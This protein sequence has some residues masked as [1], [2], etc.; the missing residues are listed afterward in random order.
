[1]SERMLVQFAEHLDQL[2]QTENYRSF[3]KLYHQGASIHLDG[4]KL[5]NLAS[6]D[7]LGV[8]SDE[9]LQAQF[10]A[11]YQDYL[12]FGSSSSRL[13]T[14][15]F[16]VYEM[17]EGRMG[18]LFLGRACLLFN[19]GYHANVGILPAICDGRTLILADKLVHASIID[20]MRLAAANGTKCVR[21]QHQN[22]T[23]LETLIQKYHDDMSIDRI[24][25]V[26]E[27]IFSMDGDVTDLPALVRLKATYPK[28][29]LYIDEA[30]AIGVRG[31]QGLGCA[32]AFG[33]I[34]EIDLIVGAFG[35]AMAS[36]GGY[37]ICHQV[38]KDYLINTMRPLIFSTALPPMN[39]AWTAFVLD[40]I[41]GMTAERS[42]LQM[43]HKHL[44]GHIKSLGFECPSNSQIVPIILKDNARTMRATDELTKQGFFVLGVRPPTVPQNQSRLRV[45]LNSTISDDEF[46]QFCHA[47]GQLT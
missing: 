13:L 9:H 36:V 35:K 4:Q 12:P 6:N 20:G 10:L 31:Q 47:I 2:K 11:A 5:V 19:S 18:E 46:T 30:H 26:T 40:N 33:C 25:I 24:V 15:N 8:A 42:K 14:G 43:R 7:Y 17:L 28:L 45:C 38:I 3:R 41:I 29:M 32:E 1:M 16:A 22:L 39:V 27:S 21:Y 37:V 34:D 44:I 23:H